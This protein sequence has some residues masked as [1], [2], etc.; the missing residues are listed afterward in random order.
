MNQ[1]DKQRIE[2]ALWVLLSYGHELYD[3]LEDVQ[4][5]DKWTYAR[6]VIDVIAATYNK[7]QQEEL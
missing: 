1:F 4:H 3:V 6:D 5:D 7:L 2:N